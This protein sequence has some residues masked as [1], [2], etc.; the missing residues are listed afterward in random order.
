MNVE[1]DQLF[2]ERHY[3]VQ[4][5]ALMWHISPDAIR[6]LFRNEPGV[7]ILGDKVG[8][9][10]RPYTTMRIPQSVLERVHN[11]SSL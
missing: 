11:L 5:V 4:E 6:K 3:A 1:S 2:K 10:K 7:L 8:R 9:R